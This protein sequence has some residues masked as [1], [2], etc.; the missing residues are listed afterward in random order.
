VLGRRKVQDFEGQQLES[1]EQLGT[2]I[3]QQSGI[4]T[5]EV[6]KDSGFSQSVGAGGSTTMRYLRW[7]PPLVTTDCRIR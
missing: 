6:D 3:E 4:G 2:A 1:T 7:S 5:G